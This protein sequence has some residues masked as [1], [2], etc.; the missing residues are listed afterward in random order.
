MEFTLRRSTCALIASIALAGTCAAAPVLALADTAAPADTAAAADASAS[1][2]SASTLYA[3]YGV[4]IAI[5]DDFE[6]ADLG[7]TA[8]ALNADGSA[9]VSVTPSS[10]SFDPVPDDPAQWDDYFGPVIEESA[11][12]MEADI[13]GSETYTLTD[14]TEAYLAVL[15]AEEDGQSTIVA[16]MYVPL[17][18]GTFTQVQVAV[19][20][21]DEYSEQGDAILESVGLATDEAQE[22]ASSDTSA[23]AASGELTQAAGIEFTLPD[24]Y[25]PDE[26]S[27]EDEPAWSSADGSVYVALTPDVFDD[28]S[29]LGK[30]SLDLAASLVIDGIGGTLENAVEYPDSYVYVFSGDTEGQE[31]IGLVCMVPL[32]D[33]SV[34]CM[35]VITPMENA[36]ASDAEVTAM[37]ESV[38]PA[39]E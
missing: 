20:D 30:E 34:T 32:P 25:V 15:T 16:Q 9:A 3:L 17:E 27:T 18:D 14:G 23:D 24:G 26:T 1:N 37:V 10:P 11:T 19:P 12:N 38:H 7:V 28:Y 5:P 39:Q 6:V 13:L 21:D 8:I 36:A 31:F 2:E 4:Q 35:L 22:L 33:D 29:T